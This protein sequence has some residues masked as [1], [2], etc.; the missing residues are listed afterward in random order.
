MIDAHVHIGNLS[1]APDYKPLTVEQLISTMDELGIQKSVLLPL[2]SPEATDGY[3]TTPEALEAY[4]QYP[5]RL[6]PFCVVDPRRSSIASK[7]KMFKEMG[8]VGFGEHKMGL[9]IDDPRCK[10]I[11]ET[12]NELGF[13]VLFHLDPELNIDENG[14]PRL[15]KLLREFPNANF[16]MHGPGWWCE[17]SGDCQVRGGYPKGKITP[18]GAVDRLL[19]NYPNIYGELSAGSGYNALNRDPDFT[20]GFFERNWKQLLFGTDYLGPGQNLP[21]VQ[22][23]KDYPLDKEKKDAIAYKNIEEILRLHT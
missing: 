2:D 5:D 4:K 9:E 17:I 7:I 23:L 10:V 18:G 20:P 22:F 12:C 13:S 19:Q 15:E 11:Y 16:L 21:I 8:C 3:F 14:L 1:F 6:I